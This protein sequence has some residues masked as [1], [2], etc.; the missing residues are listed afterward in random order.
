MKIFAAIHINLQLSNYG[1]LTDVFRRNYC[2][3]IIK[4]SSE[5]FEYLF[6]YTAKIKLVFGFLSLLCEL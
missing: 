3:K 2:P 6:D 4:Q 5:K 1:L